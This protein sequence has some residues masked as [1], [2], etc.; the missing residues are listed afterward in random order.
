MG[1]KSF[2]F[3]VGT[4]GGS[5][6]QIMSHDNQGVSYL[7]VIGCWRIGDIFLDE[8]LEEEEESSECP[9]WEFI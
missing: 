1:L 3:L 4:E 8:E 7:V 5:Y 6:L 2:G 9:D